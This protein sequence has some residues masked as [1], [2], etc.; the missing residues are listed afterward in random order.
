VTFRADYIPEPLLLFNNDGTAQNP[1]YGLLKYGLRKFSENRK[2]FHRIKVGIIGTSKSISLLGNLF[3]ELSSK[4]I[5]DNIKPWR[6]PFPGLN[7]KSSLKFAITINR[8]WTQEIVFDELKE[9]REIHSKND[10]IEYILDLI[11]NKLDVITGKETPPDVVVICIPPEV[12]EAFTQVGMKKPLI[13]LDNQDDFHNRI[14]VYGMKYH[15]PTQII[16]STTLLRKGTQDPATLAWNLSVGLLYKAQRG[17]P[18]KLAELEENTCYVGISFYKEYDRTKVYTRTSMAQ[19]FLDTGESFGLRGDKFEWQPQKREKRPHLSEENAIKLIKKVINQYKKNK[20]GQEPARIVIHKSSNYWKD[21]LEGFLFGCDGIKKK[22]FLTIQNTNFR[23][24]RPGE[25]ATMRGT[26]ISCDNSTDHY[27]Y[28]TGFVP[29]LK[30]F[31][32]LAIP[33]P[34]LVR[35]AL[36]GT[37]PIL[38]SK[39]EDVCE[40]ILSL[41]KLDWN[42]V[43]VYRRFPVT[44]SISGKV[45]RIL[46]ESEAKKIDKIDRHYYFYM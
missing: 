15:I 33:N 24:F 42:N 5:P 41:T 37:T 17:H 9:L 1:C 21:E 11:E 40:E 18:W 6:L 7:K 22:D 44:L 29:T 46:A 35:A 39:I 43:F 12:E 31:P 20:D 28:T 34:I 14:K 3:E 2:E 8:T 36:D 25:Y 38:D 27:L 26:L 23:F 19:V 10:K 4:I 45:G 13:K 30:T 16:R 32:G